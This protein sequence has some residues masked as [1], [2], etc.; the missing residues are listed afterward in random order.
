MESRS[1]NET[2]K[3]HEETREVRDVCDKLRRDLHSATLETQGWKQEAVEA[4]AAV[5]PTHFPV[6]VL[7][8]NWHFIA[9]T[10]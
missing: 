9:R 3:A 5:S 6:C 7:I 8:E 1:S 4:K 10:S 2:R